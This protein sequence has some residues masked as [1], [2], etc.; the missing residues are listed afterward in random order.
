MT[1][2]ERISGEQLKG[3]LPTLVLSILASEPAHGYAIMQR[4]A[5]RSKGV[6]ELGQ[7]TVYPLLYS[8]E[9]QGLIRSKTQTV[10]GRQR[11]VY[12]ATRKGVNQMQEGRDQWKVFESAMNAVLAP[13]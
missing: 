13:C 7:G 11:R 10:N 12:S 4:L 3:H 8:M 6:F 1:D 5:L 9:E 2:T